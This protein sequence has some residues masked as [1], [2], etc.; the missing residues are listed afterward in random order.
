MDI[1]EALKASLTDPM[2][3]WAEIAAFLPNLLGAITLLVV[4]HFLGKLVGGIVTRLLNKLGLD[5]LSQKAGLNLTTKGAGFDTT[6]SKILGNI[7]YWLLFLTFLISAADTLGLERV[8]ATID[9]FVLYLPKVVGALLVA[10]IGLFVAG[11]VRTTV[12]TALASMNLGYERAVASVVHGVIVIVVISLAIGQLEIETDL[13]NEVVVLVLFAGAA[14]I[15]LSLG[16]G[17]RD[18]A[19]SVIAGAYVRELYQP[20]DIIRIG[21]VEGTVLEVGS[22]SIIIEQAEGNSIAV[23]NRKVLDEQVEIL[24]RA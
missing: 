15:S 22:T 3:I 24:K 1:I 12:E 6:P 9:N 10:I 14:A 7:I 18:V 8:S 5:Q 4:G 17:T 16:L 19:G 13:L 20:G 21:K 2:I 23:P 11:F